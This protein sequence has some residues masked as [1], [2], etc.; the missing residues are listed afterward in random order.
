MEAIANWTR[1]P[2][3]D[4]GWLPRAGGCVPDGI[5]P[6]RES[7]I[8]RRRYGDHEPPSEHDL[9]AGANHT[10]DPGIALFLGAIPAAARRVVAHPQ[11]QR[12]WVQRQRAFDGI[13]VYGP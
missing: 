1:I 5:H 12:A 10:S 4:Q 13:S 6:E 2:L 9:C 7:E 3:P 11:T 8:Q